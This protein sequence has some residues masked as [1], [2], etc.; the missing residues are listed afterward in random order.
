[1]VGGMDQF[2]CCGI[3]LHAALARDK[4]MSDILEN[5]W[6]DPK[7]DIKCCCGKLIREI[8]WATIS[9]NSNLLENA[10]IFVFVFFYVMYQIFQRSRSTIPTGVDVL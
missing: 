10:C 4:I 1:M 2:T 6:P 7:K 5:L 3:F 8:L 9:E